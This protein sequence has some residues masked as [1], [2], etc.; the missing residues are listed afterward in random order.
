MIAKLSLIDF[1]MSSVLQSARSA[2]TDVTRTG[3][4]YSARRTTSD[5]EQCLGT[6]V[7]ERFS[8]YSFGCLMYE[9]LNGRLPFA[10][11]PVQVIVKHL[12]EAAPTFDDMPLL[13]KQ[14]EQGT[15]SGL[16]Q[17]LQSLERVVFR[18]LKKDAHNRYQSFE[19]LKNDL[20]SI[21]TDSSAVTQ[22]RPSG[23]NI[24]KR[25]L[26]SAMDGVVIATFV[27]FAAKLLMLLDLTPPT[28]ILRSAHHLRH[29]F[30]GFQS[31]KFKYSQCYFS[32]YHLPQ[33]CSI[34]HSSY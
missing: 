1:G 9:V 34:Y 33:K 7:D 14:N 27:M 10:V 22:Y 16:K 17:Q 23:N 28:M 6:K 19:E 18:C 2:V 4:D 11:D 29:F 21:Q 26:A 5:P 31:F 25:F 32:W 24:G 13:V 12:K 30:S 8:I 15:Y 20:E 3:E